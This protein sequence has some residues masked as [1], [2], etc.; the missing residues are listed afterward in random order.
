VV[1]A[2]GAGLRAAMVSYWL[3]HL[4]SLRNEGSLRYHCVDYFFSF[5]NFFL[6]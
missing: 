2:G 4:Q 3:I 5:R 6:H 1:G